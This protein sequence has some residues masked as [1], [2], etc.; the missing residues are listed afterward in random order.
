M[1]RPNASLTRIFL[2]LLVGLLAPLLW[3][4]VL[5]N[6]WSTQGF[7]ADH[8]HDWAPSLVLLHVGSDLL[9]GLAY[10]VIAGLLALMVSRNREHLPFDWVVLAFGLF[11]VACGLTHVMHVLVR[12]YPA[13]WL[14]GYLRAMTAIVSVATAAA[15]PPLMPKVRA[16]LQATAALQRKEQELQ[17]ALTRNVALLEM[18]QLSG[19]PGDVLAT[20]EQVLLKFRDALAADWLGIAV[21]E[22]DQARLTRVWHSGRATG[23]LTQTEL[24]P[25]PRGTGLAW[26][27]IEAQAPVYIAD[28]AAHPRAH[29]MYVQEGLSAV[30]LLPLFDAT[31]GQTTVLIVSRVHAVG[32]W[33]AEEQQL[34]EAARVALLVAM[35][36]QHHLYRL[37][38][39]ALQDALTGLGNRRAFEL[40]LKAEVASARRHGYAFGLMMMDLDGLKTVNDELGHDAGDQLL[41]LFGQG[42]RQ[43]QR[44]EDRCYRL[45]GDEFAVL[46]PHS[47]PSAAAPCCAARSS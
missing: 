19:Q 37:E 36:R 28:Y 9:I 20:A 30:A 1:P 22:G 24:P 15:L 21:Q 7:S 32:P 33:T 45:G 41:R 46:L 35:E 47:P 8:H 34:F 14:D 43:Q 12:I 38:T 10:T 29:P 16:A 26:L 44:A 25:V 23:A 2:L 18:V 5:P 17:Q 31:T 27:A 4:G 42:L 40:D 39:A 13:Y 3:P 11:I 6:L